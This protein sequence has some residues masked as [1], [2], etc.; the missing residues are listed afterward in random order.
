MTA[1]ADANAAPGTYSIGVTQLA[2]AQQLVSKPFSGGS[3]QT[4]GTGTLTLSLGSQSVSVPID[5][6]DNTV[7]GIA[8][9][10]NSAPANPG[11]TA[12]IVQGT[13]GAHLVLA[14]SLT[15]ASNTIQ[16]SAAGGD[17]GL[18]ALT[19][20]SGHTTNYTQP[21]AAQD[22]ILTV[23]GITSDSPSNTDSGAITGVT[24]NLA[25]MTSA[26][27]PVTLTVSNDTSTVASNISN[28]VSA[29]NAL[30]NQFSTLGGYDASSGTA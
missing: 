9:A 1:T 12:G 19:Y 8:A 11:I 22:A 16:V 3:S 10:I 29:Y 5:S 2:Q 7:A 15:G 17:G 26:G 21:T 13:D 23:A 20:S 14:S 28:F 25:S 30:V 24:L 18:S 4:V 27:S 6:T